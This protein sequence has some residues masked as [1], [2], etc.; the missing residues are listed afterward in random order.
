MGKENNRKDKENQEAL[1]RFILFT[2]ISGIFFILSAVFML[3][4][5]GWVKQLMDKPVDLLRLIIFAILDGICIV[6]LINF[7]KTAVFAFEDWYGVKLLPGNKKTKAEIKKVEVEEEK[8]VDTVKDGDREGNDK[9][10]DGEDQDLRN[11]SR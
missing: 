11:E 2:V 7:G 10:S 4:S 8:A 9:K 5:A 3:S 6:C 1:F